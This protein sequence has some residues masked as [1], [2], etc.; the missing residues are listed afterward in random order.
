MSERGPISEND[1]P[2]LLRR[3][4]EAGV[5]KPLYEE[6]VAA[7][8][9]EQ[10]RAILRNAITKDAIAHGRGY[11]ERGSGANDLAGFADLLPQWQANDALR[12]EVLEQS[13]EKFDFNV[14]RCR[15]AEMYRK[16]GLTE[17]GDILSCGRDGTF[18]TG[19]NPAIELTRGQTIMEG[20]SHC[21]FRYRMGKAER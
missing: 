3:R 4:I 20:A 6:M 5:I 17:I 21:D 12:V 9:T 18:C 16:M 13:D 10:A 1:L 14:T 15:Y 11:A 2:I 7:L 19:Y 8:G